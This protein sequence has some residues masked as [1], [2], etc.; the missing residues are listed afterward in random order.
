M[1]HLYVHC[2]QKHLLKNFIYILKYS[3]YLTSAIKLLSFSPLAYANIQTT[4][5]NGWRKIKCESVFIVINIFLV[6]LNLTS[7]LRMN[8]ILIS[9]VTLNQFFGNFFIYL[10]R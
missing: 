1:K 9:F 10:T 5:S 6:V 8:K 4:L 7:Y 3:T 2:I